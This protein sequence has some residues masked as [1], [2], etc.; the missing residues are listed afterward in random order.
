MFWVKTGRDGNR[1]HF[2]CYTSI[3]QSIFRS[4]RRSDRQPVTADQLLREVSARA[5]GLQKRRVVI[6]RQLQRPLAS[7]ASVRAPNSSEAPGSD[8]NRLR[9]QGSLQVSV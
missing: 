7:Q 4:S 6:G 9:M 2:C 1:W 8:R 3:Y 5:P